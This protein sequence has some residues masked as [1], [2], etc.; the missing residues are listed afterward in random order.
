MTKCTVR[1]GPDRSKSHTGLRPA[2]MQ[3]SLSA[4][5]SLHWRDYLIPEAM[6]QLQTMKTTGTMTRRMEMRVDD[7]FVTTVT[8]LAQLTHQSKA[9]VLRD[10]LNLYH[11][12]VNEYNKGR[13][14]V[15]KE[16]NQDILLR[17]GAWYN[18]PRNCRSAVRIGGR[19][20]LC[21]LPI[22]FRVCCPATKSG[23]VK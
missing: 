8:Q 1:T 23:G 11:R 6:P 18:Y 12:A 13:G 19:P 22:G 15:F 14:I 4:G 17:G 20:D 2:L 5:Q 3:T 10:A 16:I 21:V 7:A 9:E